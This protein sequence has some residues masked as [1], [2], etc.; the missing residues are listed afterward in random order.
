[1]T[2]TGNVI[3][4]IASNQKVIYLI[5]DEKLTGIKINKFL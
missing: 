4:V 3:K 5:V 1:M 2:K